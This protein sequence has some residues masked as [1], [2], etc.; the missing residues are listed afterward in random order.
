[1]D[2]VL[3]KDGARIAFDR[4][5]QGPPI[6]LVVGAFNDRSTGAPLAS[7][8]AER[9]TTFT[10]DRRGRGDSGDQAPYDVEREL[11]DLAALLA[12]AGGS[13]HVFGYSSGAILALKAAAR[14][15]PIAKLALYEAPFGSPLASPDHPARLAQLIAEGRRGDAVE[16]FQAKVV[17]IPEDVVA[18]LR[19]APFRPA[20]ERMA[21]TLVYD[22]LITAD[23]S[24]PTA[25]AATI[26]AP[27]L[28]LAG[29]ASF[30]FMKESARALARALPH[31]EAR[32]LEGQSHDLVPAALGPVLMRFFEGPPG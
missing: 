13:A 18:R 26:E 15:L 24:I 2:T 29:G 1:M 19:H 25:L 23:A 5:G 20:L 4:I 10:Y 6:I 21:P 9:F 32:I 7:F 11:E 17:G 16:Y 3:S 31:G 30:P 27:T 12:A 22:S 28:V 14:G 8:L